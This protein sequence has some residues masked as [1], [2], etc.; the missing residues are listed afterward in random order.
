MTAILSRPQ[1]IKL[2]EMRFGVHIMTLNIYVQ[3]TYR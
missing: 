1:Y 2:Y 3:N